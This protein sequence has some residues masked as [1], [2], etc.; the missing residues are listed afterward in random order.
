MAIS[1]SS[2][3]L[4]PCFE[5]PIRAAYLRHTA[6]MHDSPQG[7]GRVA[8]SPGWRRPAPISC[9]PAPGLGVTRQQG[10]HRPAHAQGDTRVGEGRPDQV[11]G[12]RGSRRVRTSRHNRKQTRHSGRWVCGSNSATSP[13]GICT[14]HS[15]GT[16]DFATDSASDAWICCNHGTHAN[17]AREPSRR[18]SSSSSAENRFMRG[19]QMFGD[20]G[21]AGIT[22][23]PPVRQPHRARGHRAERHS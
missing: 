17:A 20:V 11:R 15:A 19:S 8:A 22:T 4:D 2:T 5:R 23:A 1:S 18:S 16:T 6:P 3:R 10:E 21:A 7:I 9:S 12:A 13:A 14:P